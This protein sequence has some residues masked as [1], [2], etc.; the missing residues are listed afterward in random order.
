M[1][2]I[3]HCEP[4]HNPRSAI[5]FLTLSAVTQRL[6][7][8]KSFVYASVAEGSLPPPVRMG[9]ARRWIDAEIEQIQ[10]LIVRGASHAEQIE[11]VRQLV[12]ARQ[13]SS[14]PLCQPVSVA[15]RAR[16]G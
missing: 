10:R 9:G 15:V 16:G 1:S 2:T 4:Q 5:V 12:E 3:L 14:A 7:V 13:A 6:G 11:L 8:G